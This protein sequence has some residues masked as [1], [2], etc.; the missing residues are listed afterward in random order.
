MH[1]DQNEY[2]GGAEAAFSLQEAGEWVAKLQEGE[3]AVWEEFG[4]CMLTANRFSLK[5]IPKCSIVEIGHGGGEG[6]AELFK[7]VYAY[8]VAADHIHEVKA[9]GTACKLEGL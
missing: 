4:I 3:F 1:V 5:A 9:T 7:S 6:E 2:Y 8:A